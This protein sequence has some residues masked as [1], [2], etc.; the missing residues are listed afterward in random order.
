MFM[1]MTYV[2]VPYKAAAHKSFTLLR[3]I[4]ASLKEA[5][6]VC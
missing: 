4:L 2:I 1:I 5:V 3:C 6:W